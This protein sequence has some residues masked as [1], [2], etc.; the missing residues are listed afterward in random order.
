MLRV[1]ES[2]GL[3]AVHEG[4]LVSVLRHESGDE[5]PEETA[6]GARIPFGSV[7]PSDKR[8]AKLYDGWTR[9]YLAS[10]GYRA[11]TVTVVQAPAGSG[12]THLNIQIATNLASEGHTVL[13]LTFNKCAQ[14]EC[15]LRAKHPGITC[16]TIDSMLS[17]VYGKELRG[18]EYVDTGDSGSLK[19]ALKRHCGEIDGW[20]ASDVYRDF[21][22]GCNRGIRTGYPAK[23]QSFLEMGLRGQ[24]WWTYSVLRMRALQDAARW[25]GVFAKYDA[26]IVD[27]AQDINTVM[28]DLLKRVHRDRMIL[29]TMDSRQKLYG[30]LG[31]VDITSYLESGSFSTFRLYITFRQGQEVCDMVYDEGLS[32]YPVY[33]SDSA[34]ETRIMTIEDH[35]I[36]DER[37][38]YLVETWKEA[39]GFMAV[40][41]QRGRPYGMEPDKKAE[42]LAAC[43]SSESSK[44]DSSLFRHYS[45]R[46]V[47][48]L[49]EGCG[50]RDTCDVFVSTVHGFKGLEDDVVRV[51]GEVCRRWLGNSADN[52]EK[53]YVAVTRAMRL[54]YLPAAMDR[55]RGQS[56]E[57]GDPSPR[58][59]PSKRCKRA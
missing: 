50:N 55:K 27:E 22:D 30:F 43:E 37:H 51:S 12:K 18:L 1:V 58:Q 57:D 21:S 48:V 32:D 41:R 19:A 25:L 20:A 28:V 46:E 11:N 34:P 47:V 5:A 26:V 3:E 23:L 53:M 36:P 33:S 13:I 54:L 4:R 59:P 15:E 35:V 10:R 16:R 9:S 49:L 40:L 24:R 14:Q 45:K 31:N 56:G 42:I 8:S 44:Y 2:G 38:V 6:E 17:E 7:I 29:Y 52:K 39:V